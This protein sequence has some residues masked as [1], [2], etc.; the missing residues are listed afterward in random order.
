MRRHN[1]G[2]VD[3]V[4]VGTMHFG[5]S[6]HVTAQTPMS[7]QQPQSPTS[8]PPPSYEA[9]SAPASGSRT[10]SLASPN[11][12]QLPQIPR[13]ESSGGTST[14]PRA[15]VTPNQTSP[16]APAA[17]V[18]NAPDPQ[19]PAF[20]TNTLAAL[21]LAGDIRH[22]TGFLCLILQMCAFVTEL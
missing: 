7:P 15:L 9:A 8:E 1:Q 4:C 11:P 2:A 19:A 14:V 3:A 16:S 18:G 21:G 22:L 6:V 17:P 13:T 20:F 5:P 12:N 10:Q